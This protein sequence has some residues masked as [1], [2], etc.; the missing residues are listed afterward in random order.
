MFWGSGLLVAACGVALLGWALFND[1]SRGRRRCC[2]CWYSMEHA[3]SLRCP[4]CGYEARSER[5]L[6]KT[7]RRWRWAMASAIPLLLAAF[8]AV[9]PKV[10]R[11]GWGSVLPATVMILILRVDDRP[12]VIEGIQYHITEYFE[13]PDFMPAIPYYCESRLWRWQWR[14]LGRTA[15]QRM[16]IED[17]SDIRGGYHQWLAVIRDC[18]DCGP[19]RDDVMQALIAEM[20]HDDV[21]V[22]R[23]AVFFGTDHRDPEGSTRRAMA[24]LEDD[25]PR[26]RV[27]AVSVLWTLG[28]DYEPAKNA[29]LEAI[30]HEDPEVRSMAVFAIG[31]I[32][33]EVHFPEGEAALYG[34][35]DDPSGEVRR[36]RVKSLARM[37]HESDA[38]H[39]IA[40]ALRSEDPYERSGGVYAGYDMESRPLYISAMIIERLGDESDIVRDMAVW[41]VEY[42]TVEELA[43]RKETLRSLLGHDDE[44]V[45]YAASNAL[46]RLGE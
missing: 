37:Q 35:K 1:R 34:L 10:Q 33:E 41:L 38:R 28:H 12:W 11:D 46:R 29:L 26:T 14:L 22:R 31:S 2:K 40:D 44:A 3:P 20:S 17:R 24:M 36:Y 45:R 42:L 16:A 4:E 30:T 7:R 19:I 43:T 13:H 32:G 15:L 6:F 39:T 27:G 25:D 5:K 8:L 18:E 21:G 23:S 9:Q